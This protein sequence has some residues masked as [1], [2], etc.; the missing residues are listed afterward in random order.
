MGQGRGLKKENKGQQT[1]LIG[2]YFTSSKGILLSGSFIYYMICIVV[3]P[4]P[5]IGNIPHP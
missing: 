4:Y 5:L 1:R 3:I 2:F